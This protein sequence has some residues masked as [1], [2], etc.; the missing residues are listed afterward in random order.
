VVEAA[1]QIT[2]PRVD[3]YGLALKDCNLVGTWCYNVFDFPRYLRVIGTGNFPVDRV[4]THKVLLEDIVDEGFEVL[5][6]PKGSATKVLV[7]LRAARQL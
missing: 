6:D 2:E 7:D 3:L 4:I 1:L 5:V